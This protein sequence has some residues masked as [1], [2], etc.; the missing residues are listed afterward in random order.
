MGLQHHLQSHAQTRTK[1]MYKDANHYTLYKRNGIWGYYYYDDQN[2]RHFRSTG[3]KTKHEALRV[4]NERIIKEELRYGGRSSKITLSEYARDFFIEGK[5]P[6]L[7]ERERAGHAIA[8]TTASLYRQTLKKHIFPYIGSCAVQQIDQKRIKDWQETLHEE[9]GIAYK[10][11]ILATSVLKTTLKQAIADELLDRDPFFGVAN[12]K[13][14]AST[15]KA[16]TLEQ[17]QAILATGWENDIA[18]IAFKTACLTGMRIGEIQA[19]KVSSL[20]GDCIE[21]SE[22]YSTKLK[23]VKCTKNGKTRIVPYPEQIRKELE[24]LSKDRGNDDFLFSIDG[25]EPVC[26]PQITNA[27]KKQSLLAGIDDDGLTFHS[28]R[29]FFDSY[30]YLTAGVDKER[31]M[32]VIGHSSEDMFRHYLTIQKEDLIPIKEAQ[33]N[34]ILE[35]A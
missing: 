22:S 7:K 35:K 14:E 20:K 21:V 23:L 30:L 17:V 9:A 11:I 18:R 10:T 31:I 5:C 33:D 24:F 6:I 26:K 29:Y 8:R 19:L 34:M 27:L 3:R 32:K 28:T 12:L 25:K 2:K 4:I 16:F 13:A 1:N 15:R